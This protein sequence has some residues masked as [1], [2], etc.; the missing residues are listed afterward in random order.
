MAAAHSHGRSQDRGASEPRGSNTIYRRSS[1]EKEEAGRGII[2]EAREEG[3][4]LI[5]G[6]YRRWSPSWGADGERKVT[7]IHLVLGKGRLWKR[8]AQALWPH[9]DSDFFL[10]CDGIVTAIQPG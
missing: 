8:Q 9:S 6:V 7:G 1:E 5:H 3:E 2:I 10:E 4:Q